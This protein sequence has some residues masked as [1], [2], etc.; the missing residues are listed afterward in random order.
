WHHE[1]YDGSGYPD[2]LR[3]KDIPEEA[4]IIA[5]ADAYDAM[6]SNR[7]YRHAIPQH[8][9]REELVKG[10]GTQFDPEF[11]GI[12]IHMVDLDTEYLMKESV[13]GANITNT[14]SLRCDEIYHG[15]S[16]G[17]GVTAKMAG[18]RICSQPDEGVADKECLPTLILY[19]SLDGDV[20]PGEE[21]N[22]NLLYCEYAQIRLDGKVTEGNIRKCEV[23]ESDHSSDIGRVDFGETERGQRYLIKAVRNRDHVL[24]R[25]SGEEKA[26]DVILALPDTSRY[27]YIALSGEHCEIHNIRVEIDKEDFDATAIP[28]IANEISYIRDSREGDLP[29]LQI[30]GPQLVYSKGVPIEDDLMLTF[31]TR[32]LPTARLIWH[33]PYISIFSSLNGQPDGENFREYLILRF[34][35]EVWSFDDGIVND[36]QVEKRADFEGW[37]VWKDRN[38][39]GYECTVRVQKKDDT[40][41]IRTENQG[42]AISSSSKIRDMS[43]GIN[44]ALTGDQV[45]ITDIRVTRG[46]EESSTITEGGKT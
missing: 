38:K 44:L 35:G 20:H 37:N 17:I 28:R 14:D 12:M 27:V 18:I 46:I 4:R 39:E 22:R 25:V 7:S 31:H 10:I 29:N 8:I 21:E 30:D 2:G 43:H 41:T 26:F 1:R 24:V 33:C 34:D 16:A 32:S 45:A 11:A 15:C 40:I 3:G 5:V 6:T 23:R 13:S 9:V 19:D 36:V 42:I